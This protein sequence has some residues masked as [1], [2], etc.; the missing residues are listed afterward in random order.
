VQLAGRRFELLDPG[1]FWRKMALL[2]VF[3]A[4]FL[5]LKALPWQMPLR[6]YIVFLILLHV[7]FVFVLVYRVRWRVLA[8]HRRS[9]ILRLFAV[10]I[11]IALL[12][13]ND[14]GATFAEFAVF[15]GISFVLHTALLLSLALV[16]VRP[17]A[18]AGQA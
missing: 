7:Y 15:L 14:A 11:F 13:V 4:A 3:S 6:V 10:A 1:L 8:E 2:L 17:T 16:V 18:V 12:A 5:P 9:F